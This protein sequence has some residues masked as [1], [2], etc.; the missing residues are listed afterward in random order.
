MSLECMKPFKSVSLLEVF[1]FCNNHFKND[2]N[3]NILL[4]ASMIQVSVAGL[5]LFICNNTSTLTLRLQGAGSDKLTLHIFVKLRAS[6][7]EGL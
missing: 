5:V 3:V 1:Y 7:L 6:V 2:I 4:T